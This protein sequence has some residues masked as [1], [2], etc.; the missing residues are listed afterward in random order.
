MHEAGHEVLE[1][2][3]AEACNGPPGGTVPADRPARARVEGK[4]FVQ[5][6]RYL[7]VRGVTYGPFAPNSAGEWLPD[8]QRVA[9]DFT[10]MRAAGINAIRIYHS[11]PASLLRQ[12]DEMGM[13]LF[14]DVPWRKHLCFLDS[15]DAQREARQ[16]VQQAAKHGQGHASVL[17]YSIGNEIPPNIVRWHGRKR[18]ERFLAELAD[19]ARQADPD[20]LITYANFPPTEY[21]DL[22][23]L[24][25][26]TF[27][28]YL[29]DL[30][31]F[32]RYL[33]RL[34]NLV[35]DRPF[36]LGEL[37][38]DTL[39]HGERF[40]AEFLAGHLREATLLGLAG[41]F[42]FSWT[43]DWFTGGAAVQNWAFGI[44]HADRAPKPSY[45]TLRELFEC[46]PAKLL[47]ETPRVSVV[48]CS[49]NG[50]ATLEQCLGSLLALDYPDFEVIVVDDG[51]TDDTRAILARFPTVRAIHQSNQ[52]LSAARNVG[53]KA[54]TGSIIAYTD[55]D[56]FADA[57]WLTH[58]VHQFQ[59]TD[60]AAVGGP[61]L[62]PEDG[63]RAACV[64]A[65]PGQPTHVLESDQV[66][67]HIPGCNMAFRREALL[68]VN[69]FDP[70][71]RKAGDDVDLCWRL[72][73]A[74]YWITFAPGAF[75]WHHRRQT[76]HAYLRQQAGYG[77][78]EALLGF[79]HP[80]KFN[81]R[82]DG[83]WRGTLY[84]AS[85]RGLCLSESFIYRG[86]FGTGLFQCLYQPGPAHWAMLPST[87]EWHVAAGLVALTTLLWPLTGMTA[88][89]VMLALSVLVAALQ[90]RQA[91]LAPAYDGL[92][93][94]F[95]VMILCYIQP[96][97]RS[98][99]RYRTRLFAYH[100]PVADDEFL[101][102]PASRL[103]WTGRHTTV[104]WSENGVER[105]Q[106]LGCVVLYLNEHGWGRAID[107]GW[108]DWDVA[109]YCHPWT[110]VQ[111]CTAQEDHGRSKRLIRVRYRLRP[112]GSLNALAAV[113][114]LAGAGAAWWWPWEA[115]AGVTL[116]VVGCVGLWLRGASRATK[117][118]ALFD[119]WADDLG[120][121]RCQE[122]PADRGA[123]SGAEV[124]P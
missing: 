117:V 72:Q 14:I 67:E 112:S 1:K 54:A 7:R 96:L 102:G 93:A 23:F 101:E 79:K 88:M 62:T 58:L 81:G 27:N 32:R 18:V 121:V 11:P 47:P 89:A 104:Y 24:D 91:R 12:A 114:I 120:M 75:V 86:T 3:S 78:A 82:G 53:L 43:D 49:Y 109:V 48:V 13:N 44:T 20:S 110:I 123:R 60:A 17:A 5:G 90:A 66:A 40:Q 2:G 21:L 6:N 83:K 116:C 19:T 30:E 45:H 25:F 70:I 119:R 42:V 118:L 56:C 8:Q 63:R 46:S 98:W 15:L 50:G 57:H 35:G 105:L 61:N 69:G 97:V 41:T 106:L 103:P 26:A 68:A 31:T 77:E 59:Q 28:V 99:C 55:S 85:L 52:G 10:A 74:G 34:Q 124:E 4:F 107:S 51:S 113:A 73:Q 64:A 71:Y 37:G 16:L 80:D 108:S 95:L 115:L 76:V 87:L 39:R 65:A 22:S 111:V 122:R 38:V 29:H 33:L 9:D 100:P 94:R 36:L 84:G 92:R